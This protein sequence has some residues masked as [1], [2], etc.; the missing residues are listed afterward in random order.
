MN[1]REEV[2]I[3]LRRQFREGA[4]LAGLARTVAKAHE[5]DASRSSLTRRYIMEAFRVS[6]HVSIPGTDDSGD[7]AF[8]LLDMNFLPDIVAA[9]PVWRDLPGGGG[10]AWFDPP[11]TFPST[12]QPTDPV[13]R[14]FRLLS[15]LA[16]RLQR[17]LDEA[18]VTTGTSAP[19]TS[20]L[21]SLP[22]VPIVESPSP[23]VV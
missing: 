9:Y 1:L 17:R 23:A 3:A 5:G 12:E 16:G 8:S 10:P 7:A 14:E 13:W 22:A 20:A 18:T 15:R 21:P 11:E 4:T 19:T 2:L 6:F